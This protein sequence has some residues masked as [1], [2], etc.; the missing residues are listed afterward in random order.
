M[1]NKDQLKK[2]LTP[3]LEEYFENDLKRINHAK[4]VLSFAEDLLEKENGDWIIV[5]PA[6][7]LHDIGIKKAEEKYNSSAPNYQEKEGPAVARQIL[8]KL[9]FNDE[10]T[11]EI[12]DIIAHHHT[13]GIINTNNFKI[14]YDADW[15]VN[16]RDE[17]FIEDKEKVRGVINKLFLTKSGKEMAKK[18]YL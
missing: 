1:Q 8:S 4:N 6:S 12:C 18:I 7:I 9:S 2:Q 10:N 13:P 14:L 11:R 16:L 17:I 15:I 3:L 5:I